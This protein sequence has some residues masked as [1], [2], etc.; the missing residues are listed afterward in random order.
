MK[1][2]FTNYL[3]KPILLLLV[4]SLFYINSKAQYAYS[5]F[6]RTYVSAS[7]ASAQCIDFNIWRA[8]LT[9]T[10]YT[11]CRLTNGTTTFVCSTAVSVQAM[12]DYMRTSVVSSA[13]VSWTDG[14]N[15]W[16]IS[17]T[18]GSGIEISVKPSAGTCACDNSTSIGTLR[19]CI[20]NGNPNL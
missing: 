12:A 6:T 14:G 19:P 11:I 9:R 2:K 16:T 18:C 17:G 8:T 10:D 7:D 5:S 15:V 3:F 4:L 1:T 13:A 20:N